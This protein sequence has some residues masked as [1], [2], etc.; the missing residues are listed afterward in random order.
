[1]VKVPGNPSGPDA[2]ICEYVGTRLAAWL[3]LP[4]FDMALID[5][6]GVPRI[7]FAG[8]TCASAGTA[9]AMRFVEGYVWGGDAEGVECVENPEAMS[10]LVVLDTW[11][12]NKDRYF[13]DRH[14]PRVNVNNVFLS[15]EGARDGW[16]RMVAMDH[17]EC[18]RESGGELRPNLARI[19]R[20]K[21]TAVHGLFP[22]FV[23]HVDPARVAPFVERMSALQRG[24]LDAMLEGLPR[25]WGLRHPVRVALGNLILDRAAFLADRMIP[26][27]QARCSWQP[28]L[29]R[30]EGG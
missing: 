10:G 7:E 14:P 4:T 19:A 29:F 18:F 9:L 21:D 30:P 26:L 15:S 17:T 6:P 3:G 2:L 12:L 13:G 23:R 20:V 5:Y 22:E 8:G 16:S 27:L 1:M 11:T 25:D 28:P 24:D